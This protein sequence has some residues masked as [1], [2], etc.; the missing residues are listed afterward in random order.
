MTAVRQA[1]L[2]SALAGCV[3]LSW[4]AE[5]LDALLILTAVTLAAFSLLLREFSDEQT[6]VTPDFRLASISY[7]W[8]L[9]GAA[10][11]LALT[12]TTSLSGIRETLTANYQPQRSDLLAGRASIL[13]VAA[14]ILVLGGTALPI[15]LFPFHFSQTSL[16]DKAPGWQAIVPLLLLRLQGL[17]LLFRILEAASVGS[18]DVAQIVT[19]ISG[20][21]TCLAGAALLCRAESL[22]AIAGHLWLT[23]GGLAVVAYSIGV[24][25]P[26]GSPAHSVAGIPAGTTAAL[27]VTTLGILICISLLAL[28]AQLTRDGRR[29]NHFDELIG[30][31]RQA[32]VTAFLLATTLLSSLPIPPLPLFWALLVISGSAF[33]PGIAPDGTQQEL[34]GVVPLLTLAVTAVALLLIAA[35][36]IQPLSLMFHREP[37]RRFEPAVS[38]SPIVI[39]TVCV[40]LLILAGLFPTVL[41]DVVQRIV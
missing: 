1:T 16:F 28:D 36:L 29:P 25:S 23:F 20:A 13:G 35:R 32:P 6:T 30:L 2:L 19:G 3:L 18:E 37:L 39:A 41:I 10:F 4:S 24:T 14:T 31:G 15:G 5:T 22:R 33:A 9:C 26:A 11:L 40:A 12:G 21:A 8:L 27:G 34:A 7:V 17:G 38:Q